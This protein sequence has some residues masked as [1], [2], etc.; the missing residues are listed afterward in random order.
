MFVSIFSA[1][2]V[3]NS[4]QQYFLPLSYGLLGAI[5]FILRALSD[6]IHQHTYSYESEINFKLKLALGA[7]AGMAVGWFFASDST[8]LGSFSPLALAFLFG[9]NVDIFFALMDQAVVRV[10]TF[11]KDKTTTSSPSS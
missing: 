11:L 6:Q 8:V 4:L 3:L 9:Y 5:T 10:N 1:R 7:L 2:S